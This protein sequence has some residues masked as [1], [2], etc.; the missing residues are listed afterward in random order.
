MGDFDLPSTF[1]GNLKRGVSKSKLH[2]SNLT[3]QIIS[4]GGIAVREKPSMIQNV[5]CIIKKNVYLNV[6]ADIMADGIKWLKFPCGWISSIDMNGYRS[7]VEVEDTAMAT[8][9]FITEGLHRR[10]LASAICAMLTK[11]H[12]LISARRV[13]KSL[14]RHVNNIN[15]AG[16]LNLPDLT[17]DEILNALNSSVGLKRNEIFE[18]IK[19]GASLQSNPFSALTLITTDL[20]QIIQLRPTLWTKNELNV[21]I[22]T[23]IERQNDMFVSSAASGNWKVFRSCVAKGQDLSAMHSM[24]GYTALHAAAEFSMKE[25]FLELFALGISVN[26]RDLKKGLTPLHYVARS[27]KLEMAA[28]LLKKGADR[29]LSCNRGE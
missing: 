22:T 7:Y 8:K 15:Q 25:I 11:S 19:V 9:F 1:V 29:A 5:L 21:I 3:V 27:G 13:A 24:L 2:E 6:T 20:E 18:F 23:D 26:I 4:N 10:K 17:I 28:L 14:L 12:G 16:F